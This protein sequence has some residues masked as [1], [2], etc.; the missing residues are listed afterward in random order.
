VESCFFGSTPTLTPHPL[1][2]GTAAAFSIVRFVTMLLWWMMTGQ[3]NKKQHQQLRRRHRW[4]LYKMLQHRL[5][6]VCLV[7]SWPIGWK[8]TWN[9]RRLRWHR[10]VCLSCIVKQWLRQRRLRRQISS[11]AS[12]LSSPRSVTDITRLVWYSLHQLKWSKLF[13]FQ[14]TYCLLIRVCELL[15]VK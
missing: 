9:S 10:N 12:V 14:Q 5:L 2:P 7:M 15:V 6:G 13:I 11:L 1:V 8:T 4:S 3:T